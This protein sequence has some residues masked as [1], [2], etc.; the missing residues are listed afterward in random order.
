MELQQFT[1][2]QLSQILGVTPKTLNL[3]E[4]EGKIQATKTKGGHHRYLYHV[5]TQENIPQ[6]KKSYIYARVSSSKQKNDLQ[7]QIA[8]IKKTYPNHDVI[9]DIG[10]GIN[11]KRP[12]LQALLERVFTGHVSEI[13][14]AHR[15]RLARFGFDLLLY[16]FKRFQVPLR[17]M[18][19][20]GIQEPTNE[21]AKDLFSIITVFSARYYGSRSYKI[22]KKN[23]ILPKFRTNH[24]LK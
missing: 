5:P 12:G 17:I 3:W 16:I 13:V 1:P 7:R 11:F 15:D 20:S 4:K 24:L 14:V 10:S 9:Q 6:E 19:D 2:K 8:F 22:L 18:S 23:K 21:L